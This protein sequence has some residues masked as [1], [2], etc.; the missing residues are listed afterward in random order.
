MSENQSKFD[1]WWNSPKIKRLVGIAFSLGASLVIIGA[2]FKIL[3]LPY[4]GEM[5]GVGMT[6]EAI[7]FALGV[8]DKPHKDYEW[9]KVINFENG[10]TING[11]NPIAA[12]NLGAKNQQEVILPKLD[13]SGAIDEMQL[14]SLSE[15]IKNLNTTASQLGEL[16]KITGVSEKFLASVD[17]AANATAKFAQIQDALNTASKNLNNS[18]DGISDGMQQ[19]EKGTRNYA[20]RVETVNKNLGSINTIYE[21]Q[22]K[23]IQSQNEGLTRQTENVGNLNA[24]LAK[25]LIEMNKIKT[26]TESAS[27]STEVYQQ[28]TAKLT[29][30][31]SDLNN[32]YGNML[33]ALN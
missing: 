6:V 27:R 33:N 14:K 11:T 1:L 32:I 31:V 18:Y 5:L 19:V 15:S 9:D 28:A 7:L 26:A 2:M 8:F 3:H 10:T 16:S 25:I 20:E 22:L 17:S 4:A 29:Q 12:Q 30:Q 13:Y 24:E 23:N 21:I